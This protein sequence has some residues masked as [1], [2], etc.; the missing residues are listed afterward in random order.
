MSRGLAGVVLAAGAGTRLR[1]LTLLRPKPLCP[2]A[3]VPLVD[4]A[5]ARLSPYVED[6]AVN[7]HHHR[8]SM[9][10]H[11]ARRTHLSVEEPQALGTAGA[12]GH[13][14]EWVA[15]RDVLVTNADA[16]L[17]GTLE[18]LV[19]D[20][21]HASPRLLVMHVGAPADFGEERYVGACLL[22]WRHVER[23][24]PVPSGLYEV[25]WRDCATRRDISFARH[26]GTAIDCGTPRDYLMA[27]LHASG[28]RSVVGAGAEVHGELVRSVV[29]PGCVVE[30]GER[31]VEQ[32]RAD[33]GLTVDA[34]L[35]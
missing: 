21:D 16:Y 10:R 27:N 20:W 13:L 33:D 5:I 12:L 8:V 32:I 1:P 6:V 24:E 4:R 15:G 25:M 19:R 30:P 18:P 31:L 34:T 17:S 26:D 29:W 3:D 2:V 23:L 28:G 11:L 14:R 7:V 9:E 35:G 22:P